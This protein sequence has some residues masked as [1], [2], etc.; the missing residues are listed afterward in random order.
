MNFIDLLTN[1]NLTLHYR[2]VED[3][4]ENAKF[5]DDNDDNNNNSSLFK[6]FKSV[7]GFNSIPLLPL[8]FVQLQCCLK[9]VTWIDISEDIDHIRSI[10]EK[11]WSFLDI[12]VVLCLNN[13][14]LNN[15]LFDS[16][17]NFLSII[18][19]D[20]CSLNYFL[21]DIVSYFLELAKDNYEAN[22]PDRSIQKRFLIEYLKKSKL[23]MSHI[24]YNPY[25][26][27]NQELE[28]LCDLCELLIAPVHLYW[29][30]W[31]FLQALLRK[32]KPIFDYVNY[33]RT[34]LA[35]YYR[36]R[37]NFFRSSNHSK[38]DMAKF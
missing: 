33:G 24:I 20:H 27:T 12:P 17:T 7:M 2:L 19:F 25:K 10:F 11:N 22:Y 34:R 3:N 38:R 37:D 6:S 15:F 21:I 36:H 4:K 30:L 5:N 18:D 8:T 16:K 28:Y 29:A 1:K 31:A 35:Q 9:D 23:N 13:M 26:P 14:K 32:P